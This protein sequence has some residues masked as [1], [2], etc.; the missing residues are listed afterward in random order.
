MDLPVMPPVKPMLA[1]PVTMDIIRRA[2]SPSGDLSTR[3][4]WDGFRCIVFR[5]SDEV[6]LGTRNER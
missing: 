5:G 4:P 6:E 2:V 1:K 3:V